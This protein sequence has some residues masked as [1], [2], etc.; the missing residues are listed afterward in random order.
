[1][2]IHQFFVELFEAFRTA[3]GLKRQVGISKVLHRYPDYI[4]FHKTMQLFI[5]VLARLPMARK[6]GSQ[7]PP[8]TG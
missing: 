2:T 3:R 7:P 5:A 1:M 6:S 4:K 8:S